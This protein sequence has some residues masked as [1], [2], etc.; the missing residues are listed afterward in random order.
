MKLRYERSALADLD[1]I[2]RYIAADNPEA[3]YSFVDRVEEATKLLATLPFIG[4]KARHP[5]FRYFPVEKYLIIYE[6]KK[7]EVIIQYI[8]HGARLR[9]WEGKK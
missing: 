4:Q 5:R 3:A 6:V 1:E 2:F 9:P 7:D 8:R